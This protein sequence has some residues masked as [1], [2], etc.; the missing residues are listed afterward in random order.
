MCKQQVF[1][2]PT[3]SLGPCLRCSS[4][5]AVFW[6]FLSEK[7]RCQLE[8]DSPNTTTFRLLPRNRVSSITCFTLCTNSPDGT[9]LFGGIDHAKYSGDLHYYPVSDPS[10]GPLIEFDS[11]KVNGTEIDINLPVALDSGSLAIYF[12][13]TPFK[14]IGKALDLTNYDEKMGL[15]A[16]DCNAKVAVDFKFDGLT[17]S[18][19]SS[20]LV[21]PK[22]FFTGDT[23][24]TSCVLGVQNSQALQPGAQAKALLGEPFLKNAYVVYDLEDYKIGLAPAV[25]TDK[26]DVQ[27]V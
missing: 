12:P 7:Q 6:V 10:A 24:D 26:S 23:S 21:L 22:S 13:D 15:Y 16:I 11:L 18:A 2:S 5:P 4:R 17:I 9:I 20:S 3:S 14:A 25:Y 19:D 1:R 8:P 27:A